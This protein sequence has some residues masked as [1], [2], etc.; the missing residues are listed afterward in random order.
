MKYGILILLLLISS[1]YCYGSEWQV[2]AFN[3]SSQWFFPA[4]KDTIKVLW[5]QPMET[6]IGSYTLYFTEIP[7]TLVAGDSLTFAP[8]FSESW[9]DWE[10]GVSHNSQLYW[11]KIIEIELNV[12]KFM[13]NLTAIDH[14]GNESPP[15]DP[16]WMNV[17]ATPE[18]YT[19]RSLTI[20]IY[21]YKP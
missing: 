9:Y 20:I 8:K 2:P 21:K 10:T 11:A 19:P 14:D 18:D 3:D 17:K 15:S 4:T 12:N 5:L 6:D 16:V 1:C 7:D 13:A